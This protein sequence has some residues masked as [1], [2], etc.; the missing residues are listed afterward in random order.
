MI[1]NQEWLTGNLETQ[2]PFAESCTAAAE[3]VPS[4]LFVDMRLFLGGMSSMDVYLSEISYDLDTDSYEIVFSTADSEAIRGTL[5]RLDGGFSRVFRKQSFTEGPKIC[6]FAPGPKWDDPSWAGASSW[7]KNYTMDSG[8]VEPTL[9]NPGAQTF[10]RIFIDGQPIPPENEWPYG[11]SQKLLAGYN[12]AF[13][14]G[15]GN[16]PVAFPFGEPVEPEEFIEISAEGGLGAGY[17]PTDSTIDYIATIS[18]AAPDAEGNVNLNAVDCLRVTQPRINDLPIDHT[19]QILSDCQPCCPCAEYR[20]VSKAISRRSAKMVDICLLLNRILNDSATAYNEGVKIIN[21]LR[22]PIVRVRNVRALATNLVFSVQ[23]VSTSELFAYIGINYTPDDIGSFEIAGDQGHVILGEVPRG[24]L[25]AM[26]F[27]PGE[28]PD[29]LRPVLPYPI[30]EILT[31]GE[32]T[33]AGPFSPIQPGSSVDVSLSFPLIETHISELIAGGATTT[34]LLNASL[35]GTQPHFVFQTF[36][37]YGSSKGYSCS[38]DKYGVQIVP[39]PTIPD[40]SIENCKL[41]VQT[42]FVLVRDNNL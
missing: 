40:V 39:A 42:K 38:I 12:L 13:T 37:S 6:L 29:G 10:R 16:Y 14:R 5:S 11:V 32:T 24:S 3:P 21:R 15:T 1:Q 4:D 35:P 30:K 36:A 9:I 8:K 17:A 41:Q 28:N 33:S 25:P 7:T 2:F 20:K 31:V 27:S 26:K 19:L 34:E 18:G 22:Q 23:N